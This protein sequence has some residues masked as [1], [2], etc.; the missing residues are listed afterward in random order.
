MVEIQ[1]QDYVFEYFLIWSVI[2]VN[3][4]TNTFPGNLRHSTARW[5]LLRNPLTQN[6]HSPAVRSSVR[7]LDDRSPLHYVIT[8]RSQ[9]PES[10]DLRVRSLPCEVR[11]RSGS[12]AHETR[13][14]HTSTG[15]SRT[16]V[17]V[18]KR[19]H[20]AVVICIP[21]FYLDVVRFWY[22]LIWKSKCCIKNQNEILLSNVEN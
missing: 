8:E 12:D 1:I 20:G 2:S 9:Q 7:P 6:R 21:M 14:D 15:S 4:L 11:G 13:V 19:G 18:L 5:S 3:H 10:V 16:R 22:S 17:G